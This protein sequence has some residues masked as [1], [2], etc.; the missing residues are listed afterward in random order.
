MSVIFWL[1]LGALVAVGFAFVVKNWKLTWYEWVLAI[2]GVLLIL[3][4]VQ[5]YST[6][7][8]EHEFRA[9]NYFLVMLGVPGLILAAI[10]LVLPAM[11]VKKG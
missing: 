7:Q 2:V 3:W 1:I 5:N 8:L 11:R 9:A 10:G 6:S 4:S